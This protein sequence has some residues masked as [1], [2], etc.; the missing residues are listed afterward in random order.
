MRVGPLVTGGEQIV[1][2][3]W[4]QKAAKT[5][6]SD[7]IKQTSNNTNRSLRYSIRCSGSSPRNGRG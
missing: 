1:K 5:F 2:M 7:V 3:K 4:H 6:D